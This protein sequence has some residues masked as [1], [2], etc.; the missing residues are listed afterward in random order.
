MAGSVQPSHPE[1]RSLHPSWRW[2]GSK[3]SGQGGS[4]AVQQGANGRA[5]GLCSSQSRAP[6][7]GPRA[8]ETPCGG[9]KKAHLRTC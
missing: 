9:R 3:G 1:V 4:R 6:F 2:L 8:G 5:W 7:G